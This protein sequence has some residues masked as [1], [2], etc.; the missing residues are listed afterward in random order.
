MTECSK[1]KTKIEKFFNKKNKL[2]QSCYRKQNKKK[3]ICGECGQLGTV[4]MRVDQAAICIKCYREKYQPIHEC[5]ICGSTKHATKI[6]NN[7]PVCASC[8]R[9]KYSKKRKCAIC[10][11]ISKVHKRHDKKP[12]CQKCYKKHFTPKHECVVCGKQDQVQGFGMCRKCYKKYRY[13]NDENYRIRVLLR[14]RVYET[15]KTKSGGK[16]AKHNIDY[17]AIAQH[18]GPCPGSHSDYNI[19]HIIPLS[20]FDLTNSREVE[21]AFAPANHQWLKKEANMKKSNKY[22]KKKLKMYL[23]DMICQNCGET[24]PHKI[25]EDGHKQYLTGR[26]FC[27]KCSP[28]GGRNTRSYIVDLKENEAFCVRCQKI[29]GKEEFYIR[30]SSG[31]PFSYCVKCQNEVKL[32]KLEEKLERV[33]EERGG[34]CQDCGLSYPIPVYEFYSDDRIYQLSKAKNMSLERIKEELQGYTMLCRN[35]SAIRQWAKG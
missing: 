27:T 1:C 21:K 9:T 23:S 31:K 3:E 26:K 6:S 28:L 19:D 14:S 15:I 18:L 24:I 5:S 4:T 20:A 35:C 25:E 33:V 22:N 8:Y 17:Q 12:I 34:V 13:D 10:E 29:K 11:K 32:L 2:C 30:K 16:S 7:K